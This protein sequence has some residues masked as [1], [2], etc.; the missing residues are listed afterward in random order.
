MRLARRAAKPV[1]R[2]FLKPPGLFISQDRADGFVEAPLLLVQAQA[3][4]FQELPHALAAFVVDR[5]DLQ[6]LI[7]GECQPRIQVGNRKLGEERLG[8]PL[9][10][11]LKGD[12]STRRGRGRS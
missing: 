8:G 1:P 12:P 2:E 10:S 3:S 7:V 9:G 6:F 11:P 4:R 5:L